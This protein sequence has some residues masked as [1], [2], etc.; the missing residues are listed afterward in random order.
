MLDV[1]EHL[2]HLVNS[3]EQQ[4]GSVKYTWL[5]GYFLQYVLK[6]AAS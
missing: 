2:N 4:E 5:E 6:G 3:K 1:S